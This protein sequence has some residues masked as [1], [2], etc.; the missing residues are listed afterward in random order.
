MRLPLD[1]FSLTVKVPGATVVVP[2][3]PLPAAGATTVEPTSRSNRPESVVG[4]SAFLTVIFAA[5][6]TWSNSTSSLW[7]LVPTDSFGL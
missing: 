5:S 1:A 4:L 7:T 3:P 6:G 2:E